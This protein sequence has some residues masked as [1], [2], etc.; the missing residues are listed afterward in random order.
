MAA[1]ARRQGLEVVNAVAEQLPFKNDSY[2]FVLMVTTICF[3]DDIWASFREAHRV[4]RKDGALIIGFVDKNSRLGRKYLRRKDR[5]KF[6]GEAVF[7]GT[8]EILNILRETGFGTFD[9]KQTLMDTPGKQFDEVCD[10]Y[11]SGSFVVI[12]AMKET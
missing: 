5:S 11:G 7:F 6:Y 10:G 4:L 12:R 8:D 3:V 1:A 9:I 2:D